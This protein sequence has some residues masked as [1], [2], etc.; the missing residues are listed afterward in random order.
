MVAMISAIQKILELL[1]VKDQ[2]NSPTVTIGTNFY[3]VFIL[4]KVI[5]GLE[6]RQGRVCLLFVLCPACAFIK[7]ISRLKTKESLSQTLIF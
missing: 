2:Q 1:I 3:K 4:V 6:E 5:K 7:T